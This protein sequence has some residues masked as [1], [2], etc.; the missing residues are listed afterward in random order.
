MK[1]NTATVLLVFLNTVITLLIGASLVFLYTLLRYVSF[2]ALVG[3]GLLFAQTAL[4]VHVYKRFDRRYGISMKR[5]VLYVAVPAAALSVLALIVLSFI[6]RPYI[7]PLRWICALAMVIYSVTYLIV[8][9][10]KLA[11]F[12]PDNAPKGDPDE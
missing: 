2:T 12:P 11:E 9:P 5:Y 3:V 7:I 4:S 10:G 1:K 8:L 6:E